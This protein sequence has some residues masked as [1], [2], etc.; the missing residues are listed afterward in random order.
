[1]RRLS[2]LS[3]AVL[4]SAAL[5]AAAAEVGRRAVERRLLHY[6]D[7]LSRLEIRTAVDAEPRDLRQSSRSPRAGRSVV[8]GAARASEAPEV[9]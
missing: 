3:L 4:A 6:E 2:P 8:P 7:R 1:M 9:A 5:V